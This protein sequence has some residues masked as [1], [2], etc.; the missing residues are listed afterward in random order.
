MYAL[1]S[2]S[3]GPIEVLRLQE[4]GEYMP[5]GESREPSNGVPNPKLKLAEEGEMSPSEDEV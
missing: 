1:F 2:L 5:G 3:I 4:T